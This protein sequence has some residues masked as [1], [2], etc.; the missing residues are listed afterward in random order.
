MMLKQQIIDQISN[1]MAN[2]AKINPL[3]D[4]ENNFKAILH[5]SLEK[6]DL[7]TREEFETQQKVLINT[8]NKLD[9]LEQIIKALEQKQA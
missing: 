4:I 7:V 8:R 2:F 5:A 1:Q 6:L 9:E 3:N